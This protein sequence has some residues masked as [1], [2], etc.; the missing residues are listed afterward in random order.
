VAVNSVF[1]VLAG[2]AWLSLVVWICLVGLRGRF[3][4]MDISLPPVPAG[5]PRADESEPGESRSWPSV[6][7]VVP[8]RDEARILPD[9]FP[10]LL[11]Q[12]YPGPLRI[13]LVDDASTD[14][15]GD[16]A[17]TLAGGSSRVTVL[18][19]E[20]PAP[21]WAGKVAAMERAVRACPPS[22]YLL[23]TDA[24]IAHPPDSVRRL[25][26][27]AESGGWD[28]VSLM[29]LLSTRS[30]AERHIVPAFVYSFFQLY[31]P[32]WIARPGRRTAGAAGGCMLVRRERLERAGGLAPIAA[33]RIDDVALGHLLKVTGARTWLGV[34]RSVRSLRPYPRLADLWD[35]I[36][37]SAYTQ[38]R[39]N[40]WLL[41][42]TVL[43]LALTYGVPPLVGVAGAAAG[44]WTAAA[45]ALTA[46]LLMSLSYLPVLRLYRLA[47]WR[48]PL[49]PGVMAVYGAMTV[50]SARRHRR[51]RGGAW[52]GRVAGA[53]SARRPERASSGEPGPGALT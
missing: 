7:V 15:T 21:G 23:F 34:T 8:A 1:E 39:C 31:P 6:A 11:A 16:L 44:A 4:R 36:A 19:G 24:D 25:V 43:G 45:P 13:V 9:T 29:A 20:G 32:T 37:R 49:L 50:D 10:T 28:L 53:E 42:G 27:H 3:W 17:R 40:P 12:D 48:A 47:L 38:L 46:W 18:R 30:A 52:K 41:A 26:A 14:G 51:G 5:D 2:P 33:A 35:M 22:T